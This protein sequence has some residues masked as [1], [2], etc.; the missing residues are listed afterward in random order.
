M[1]KV[2]SIGGIFVKS[3]DPD[4]LRAW[5]RDFLGVEIDS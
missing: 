2:V 5:Y 3:R 4:V 1:P